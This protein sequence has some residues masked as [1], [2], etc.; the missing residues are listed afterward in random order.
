[1]LTVAGCRGDRHR[2]NNLGKDEN[3]VPNDVALHFCHEAGKGVR[4]SIM[5]DN[6]DSLKKAFQALM[7]SYGLDD[8]MLI[9]VS[10][11]SEDVGRAK[12]FQGGELRNV[13]AALAEMMA[14]NV[15]LLRMIASS[16]TLAVNIAEGRRS[17]TG[18]TTEFSKPH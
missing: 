14:L 16:G 17:P 4:R 10:V 11:D 6:D 5:T 8:F 9:A 3:V 1:M 13:G 12:Y 15:D 2:K 7:K 18:N